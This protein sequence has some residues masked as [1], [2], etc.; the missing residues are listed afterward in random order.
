M[1]IAPLSV[2]RVEVVKV[3]RSEPAAVTGLDRGGDTGFQGDIYVRKHQTKNKG[4][5]FYAA[6]LKTGL[7]M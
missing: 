2:T 7:V 6:P 3:A 1:S 4:A 5:A